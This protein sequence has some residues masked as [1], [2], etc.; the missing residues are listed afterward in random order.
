VILVSIGLDNAESVKDVVEGDKEVFRNVVPVNADENA[1]KSDTP[2]KLYRKAVLS[3]GLLG[4]V[5]SDMPSESY[6]NSD[7]YNVLL[8]LLRLMLPEGMAADDYISA[9]VNRDLDPAV[10]FFALIRGMLRPIEKANITS[11]KYV[12]DTLI[13]V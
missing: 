2:E 11:L 1:L 10:R 12:I 4:A 7:V 3:V 13:S 8:P 6:A 5:L 9:L